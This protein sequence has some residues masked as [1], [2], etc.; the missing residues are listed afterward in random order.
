MN[1]FI[2]SYWKPVFYFLRAKRYPVQAAE[3]LTQEFFLRVLERNWL[4]KADPQRGR[5]RSYFL[6]ILTRF[7]SDQG[8]QR[9]PRQ[10]DFERRLVSIGSLISDV[11]RSYEPATDSTPETIFMKEW[12][13]AL[14]QKVLQRLRQF[15]E[16]EGRPAWF[17]LFA[18]CH[19]VTEPGKRP[20]QQELGQRYG[21]T[22]DQVRYAL[23]MVEKRFKHFLREEVH[24]QVGSKAEVG[25]EVRELMAHLGR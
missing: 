23:E 20:S 3:D 15:Y 8:P 6:K 11:E 10:L 19:F 7:L 13:A 4:Q 17:E 5:F 22:R 1:R 24:D 12:A 14:V 2:T 18:A 9:A 16:N 25:K 21:M